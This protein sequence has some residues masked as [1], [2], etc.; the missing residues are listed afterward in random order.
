MGNKRQKSLEQLLKRPSINLEDLLD[1]DNILNRARS[2]DPALISFLSQPS[3]IHELLTLLTR[4]YS[5][6]EKSI[7]Q[8]P[9]IFSIFDFLL[10]RYP[11]L[12]CELLV[13]NSTGCA[14]LLATDHSLLEVIWS[15]L[16]AMPKID[17]HSMSYITRFLGSM[18]A[19]NP[20]TVCVY[21]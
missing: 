7:R 16:A 15:H 3:T 21:R 10:C 20:R 14:E 17:A 12:S 2:G 11:F 19:K 5:C 18:L 4:T 8:I 9:L 6:K 13:L 1:L